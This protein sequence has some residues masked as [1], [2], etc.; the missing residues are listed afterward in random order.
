MLELLNKDD[1]SNDQA[2]AMQLNSEVSTPR[3]LTLTETSVVSL[4][5]PCQTST[6]QPDFGFR[7]KPSDSQASPSYSVLPSL[8]MVCKTNICSV[9]LHAVSPPRW[10]AHFQILHSLE[11]ALLPIFAGVFWCDVSI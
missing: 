1:T 8:S 10:R 11:Y 3:E 9:N 4:A 2:L 5:K 7:P 6:Q